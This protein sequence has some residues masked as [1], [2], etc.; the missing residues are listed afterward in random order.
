MIDKGELWLFP[1]LHV[2]IELLLADYVAKR[3]LSLRKARSAEVKIS[4]STRYDENNRLVATLTDVSKNQP[5]DLKADGQ[6][7]NL[8]E[9]R[10]HLKICVA[11]D[12]F[13]SFEIEI[14]PSLQYGSTSPLIFYVEV[15]IN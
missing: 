7:T 3:A 12:F 1:N 2:D 8:L 15:C 14:R 6:E 11:P 5:K 13:G 10:D 9:T 4:E